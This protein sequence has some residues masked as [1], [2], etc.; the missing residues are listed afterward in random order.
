M[1]NHIVLSASEL[2]G[3]REEIKWQQ[4]FKAFAVMGQHVRKRDFSTGRNS[5]STVKRYNV[6][7][8]YRK[9]ELMGLKFGITWKC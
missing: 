3:I 9:Q 6:C 4:Q 8:I 7:S 5:R 2:R 1:V